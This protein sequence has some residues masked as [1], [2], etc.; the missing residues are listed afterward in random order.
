MTSRREALK[1]LMN[2]ALVAGGGGMLWGTIAK[3]ANNAPLVLRPPGALKEDK[4]IQ[5][6]I[7]CGKCVEA[8]PYDTLKLATTDKDKG[9]GTP[10]FEPRDTPCY[11]C[12]N[13]PCTE[14]CPSGAL[15]LKA[16]ASKDSTLRIENARMGLAV[17]HKE[18]CIAFSGIQC[19]ACYRSCPLM[20]EAIVLKK[21]RN[22]FTGMHAN[23]TPVINS[24]VCTG[25]GICEQVCVVDKAAIFVLPTQLAIGKIGDH[26]IQSW[27]EG[28][29][30]R[31]NNRVMKEENTQQDIESAMDY[32][33][34][35]DELFD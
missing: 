13:Y 4:F 5:A 26:D 8:C 21:E 22:K 24:D 30:A 31:I 6:C 16:L 3:G 7:K 12:T 17:V 14:A 23:L 35:E 2:S 29:E 27:K 34:T 25:C 32:L 28:D 11:L 9:L 1:K 18:S 15:D 10:Y 33:N 20:G 19:D